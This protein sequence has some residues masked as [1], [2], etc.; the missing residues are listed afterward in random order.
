MFS[1]IVESTAKI[2]RTEKNGSVYQVLIQ[3]PENFDDIKIGDSIAVNGVCLTVEKINPDSLQFAIGPETLKITQWEKN[4]LKD[5]E[6]NLER[7]MK[8]GDRI[9]GHLVT[10]HVDALGF[11]VDVLSNEGTL[12]FAVQIPDAFKKYLWK[13]GSLCISGVSLTVNE[14]D[15]DVVSFY[16]IPETLK[17]T[18][19]KNIKSGDFVNIEFDYMAKAAIHY[20]ET[21]SVRASG[22]KDPEVEQ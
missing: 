20:Q 6:V 11:V 13:K 5:S 12:F 17:K 15:D 7:S 19:L 16:L 3:K 4:L 8:L 21:C 9:H 22:L 2:L 18:N 10:G 14:V 1:G